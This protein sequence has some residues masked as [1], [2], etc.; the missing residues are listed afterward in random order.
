MSLQGSAAAGRTATPASIPIAAI[1]P[2]GFR[3]TIIR[4]AGEAGYPVAER[5]HR[6]GVR[7]RLQET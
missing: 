4:G 6:D 7:G 5:A 1:P 3:V 2:V